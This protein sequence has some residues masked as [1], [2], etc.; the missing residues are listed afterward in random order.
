LDIQMKKSFF[1]S[2]AY[3]INYQQPFSSFGQI[4]GLNDWTQSG[5]FGVSKIVS[6]KTKFFKQTKISVLWDYLSYYQI[7]ETQPFILR[8]GYTF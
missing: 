6:L 8:L 4:S 1:L 5:L 2:A 7:P 3:E